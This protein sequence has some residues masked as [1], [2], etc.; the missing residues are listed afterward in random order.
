MLDDPTTLTLQLLDRMFV[1]LDEPDEAAT[2][3]SRFSRFEE[4]AF[5][6]RAEQKR[7]AAA[8]SE[9]AE[10]GGGNDVGEAQAF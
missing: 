3:L 4:A 10:R 1:D 7:G 2:R 8:L 5:L 6:G 9:C